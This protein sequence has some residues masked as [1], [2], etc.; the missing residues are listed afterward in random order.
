MIDEQIGRAMAKFLAER[1]VAPADVTLY[2][3]G[4]AGPS[5]SPG[6]PA[7]PASGEM[8]TFSVRV[9]VQRV[10]LHRRRTCGTATSPRPGRGLGREAACTA[11]EGLVRRAGWDLSA[12]GFVDRAGTARL[13]VEG[14][15]GRELATTA[16]LGFGAGRRGPLVDAA[17]PLPA[18]ASTLALVVEVPAGELR[19]AASE[20]A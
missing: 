4:G 16:L 1:S 3:F 17:W 14:V 10:R 18:G 5:T 15:D 8:R 6:R 13:V 2:G 20:G 19:A 11:V 7:R 12:E 9:R